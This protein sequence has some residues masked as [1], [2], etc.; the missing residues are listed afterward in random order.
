MLSWPPDHQFLLASE[1]RH[2]R[3]IPMSTTSTMGSWYATPYGKPV[4][5]EVRGRPGLSVAETMKRL[6]ADNH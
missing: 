5:R 1:A 4:A 3:G 6:M 2:Q